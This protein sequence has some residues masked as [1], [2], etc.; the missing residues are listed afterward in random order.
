MAADFPWSGDGELRVQEYCPEKILSCSRLL[1]DKGHCQQGVVV[2]L[3]AP[4][5]FCHHITLH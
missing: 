2:N 1:S 3:E 4:E 5:Y